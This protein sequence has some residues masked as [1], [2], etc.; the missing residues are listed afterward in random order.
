MPLPTG[1]GRRL[2]L[3]GV[4]SG[5]DMDDDKPTAWGTAV[6]AGRSIFIALFLALVI[7]DT[8]PFTPQPLRLRIDLI[9]DV[10]GWWQGTWSMFTPD[11][12]NQNHRLKIVFAY[13]DLNTSEWASPE[14]GD[15]GV[16]ERFRG[17]RWT[18][19]F[20]NIIS[21]QN[22]AAR[23]AMLNYYVGLQQAG[24]PARRI[25][26]ATLFMRTATIILPPVSDWR[27]R[28]AA[29]TWGPWRELMVQNYADGKD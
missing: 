29:L 20:D 6:N 25:T 4:K 5:H 26:R 2:E 14:W 9:L 1:R 13:S 24:D 18:E 27:S 28:R 8:M 16:G 3:T 7:F 22:S 23:P 11:P 21:S 15:Q 10:T 19:Y 17:S 12:D